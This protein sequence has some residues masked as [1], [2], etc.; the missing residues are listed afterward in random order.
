LRVMI[1]FIEEV[2]GVGKNVTAIRIQLAT[3]ASNV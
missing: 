1:G 3:P 2:C